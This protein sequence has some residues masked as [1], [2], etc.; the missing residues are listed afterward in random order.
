MGTLETPQ[1][2]YGES[3]SFVRSYNQSMF[4]V[5]WRLRLALHFFQRQRTQV[6]GKTLE[7]GNTGHPDTAMNGV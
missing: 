7:D 6:N 5:K 4:F 1:I 2:G 3:I